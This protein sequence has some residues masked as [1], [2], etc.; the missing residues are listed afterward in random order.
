MA[1]PK[2]RFQVEVL[3]DREVNM[4]RYKR[5]PVEGVPGKY[6]TEIEKTTEVVPESFMVYFPAGHSVWFRTREDMARAGLADESVMID[7]DTGLPAEPE[8]VVDYKRAVQ[9]KTTQGPPAMKVL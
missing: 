3:H 1:K 7:E 4:T 8:P 2:P 5:V 6:T 9:R